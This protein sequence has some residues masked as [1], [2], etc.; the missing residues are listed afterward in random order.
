MESYFQLDKTNMLQSSNN[1][2]NNDDFDNSFHSVESVLGWKR[3]KSVSS[4]NSIKSVDSVKSI[5]EEVHHGTWG[6]TRITHEMNMI[7][8]K[9]RNYIRLNKSELDY[10]Y[11]LSKDDM[12]R[13]IILFNESLASMNEMLNN[14]GFT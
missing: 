4:M 6:E 12:M 2:S 8:H 9:I 11:S 14:C 13:I 7:Q 5:I 1:S 3:I 10:L